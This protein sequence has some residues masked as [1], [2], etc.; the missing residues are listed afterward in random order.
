VLFAAGHGQRVSR[1]SQGVG[2][3]FLIPQR[4]KER[5]RGE[6]KGISLP[7]RDGKSSGKRLAKSTLLFATFSSKEKVGEKKVK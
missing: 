2:N 1:G 7:T 4:D 3:S 5:P 6:G